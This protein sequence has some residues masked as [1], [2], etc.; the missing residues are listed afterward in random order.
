MI[1]SRKLPSKKRLSL[2][3]IL[4]SIVIAVFFLFVA[5]FFISRM[6]T[7]LSP[8][9]KN[10]EKLLEKRKYKGALALIEQAGHEN[11]DNVEVLVAKGKIW[12]ALAWQRENRTRWK[13]YGKDERDWLNSTEAGESEYFFKKAISMDPVNKDA[14]FFL[15]CLYMEKGWFSSAENEFLS[16]L[17]I[18]KNHTKTRINLGVLYTQM[19]RFDLAEKELRTAHK[20]EPEDPSI[21]K[22][23][24]YLYRFYLNKSDSAIAWANRYLNLDP[25]NDIDINYVRKELVEML[26]RY[27]E[28]TPSEPMKWKKP[29]RFKS[30]LRR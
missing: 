12:F 22:N 10:A 26:Q 28:F 23:F 6:N 15:G 16:V 14:H 11:D 4:I 27:P 1:E 9:V 7:E 19:K 8:S 21:A 29:K 2:A 20:M 17:R 30:R 25:Q 13:D 3:V 24:A 5:V 18:D